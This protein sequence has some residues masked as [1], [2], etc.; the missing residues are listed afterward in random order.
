MSDVRA[1]RDMQCCEVWKRDGVEPC[2]ACAE[3][4]RQEA[5]HQ[6]RADRC[7]CAEHRER[8]GR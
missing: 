5:K 1:L 2:P 3:S 6:Q 8:N 4:R 7:L